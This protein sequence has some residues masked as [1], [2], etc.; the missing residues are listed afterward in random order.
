[1]KNFFSNENALIYVKYNCT[2]VVHSFFF[3]RIQTLNHRTNVLKLFTFS[4]GG[5]GADENNRESRKYYG[6][7][8][9]EDVL[10]VIRNRGNL[11]K[12]VSF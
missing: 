6:F 8:N 2:P 4:G 5:G 12:I 11:K 3:L 1:M 9:T 10:C 7:I